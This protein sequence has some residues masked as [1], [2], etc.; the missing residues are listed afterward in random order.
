MG[1][2]CDERRVWGKLHYAF[3][4]VEIISFGLI[5]A[6][7][8]S[9]Q[10]CKGD[11]GGPLVTCYRGLRYCQ[12]IVVNVDSRS[13]DTFISTYTGQAFIRESL[14]HDRYSSPIPNT[15]ARKNVVSNFFIL[16][17]LFFT[18]MLISY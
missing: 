5:S 2:G 8:N 7:S 14:L 17:L 16:G 18:R 3:T 1:Y 11:S 12:L 9:N 13:R 15:A 4:R 6:L 10:L